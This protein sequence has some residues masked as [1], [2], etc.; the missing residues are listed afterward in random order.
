MENDEKET[1]NQSGEENQEID[2]ANIFS[3]SSSLS[4][5]EFEYL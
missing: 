1:T 4:N 2:E 5:S 3:M